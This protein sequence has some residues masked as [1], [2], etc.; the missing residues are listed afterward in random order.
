MSTAP[1]SPFQF[2]VGGALSPYAPSYISRA[3]DKELYEALLEGE[4][5]YILNARQIG[6]SSLR[7]QTMHRLRKAG[8]FCGAVDL[9][10]I[11][12]QQVTPDQWYASIVGSLVSSFQLQFDLRSWWRDRTHLS[13]INR[14]SEFIETVLLQA[15]DRNIVIFID[16][17]D[18]VLSLKFPA[19]DFFAFIRVCYNKRV[20]QPIFK[21]LSFALLGVATPSALIADKT[22]TPFNIGR[23]IELQGFR[24][25][26]VLRLVVGLDKVVSNSRAVL[27]QI[28]YWTGGQPFLTQKLCQIALTAHLKP[29][30][31][32]LSAGDE[33]RWVQDLVYTHIIDNWEAQDEPEHLRTI[34]DRLLKD[35]QQAG[36]VLGL[37]WKILS[38]SVE[39]EKQSIK[40]TYSNTAA[41]ASSPSSTKDLSAL[42]PPLNSQ[43]QN[44]EFNSASELQQ[45]NMKSQALQARSQALQAHSQFLVSESQH[46]KLKAQHLR[47]PRDLSALSGQVLIDNSL[48]QTE[49]LLS[50]LVEKR[51]NCLQVKN[52]IYQ[53]IFDLNWLQQQLK[54]IR[55]YSQALDAWIASAR[56]DTSRLLRGQALLDA[57]EWSHD[58]SL[59]DQDYQ[60]LTASQELDRREV[61]A[62][63]E[64]DRLQEVQQRLSNE[65]RNA[66]RQRFL[67]VL[68]SVALAIAISLGFTTY[69]QY[70]QTVLGEVRAIATSAEALL[71]S[72]QKLD[73]LLTSVK[74]KRLLHRLVRPSPLLQTQIERELQQSIY[75]AAEFNRLSGHQGAVLTVKTSSDGL[76]ATGSNDQSV[77]IWRQDGTLL[78]TLQHTATVHTLNFSPDGA[79]LVSSSLDG[80][81]YLWSREGK[82]I[83]RFQG[84]NVAIWNI[85]VSPDGEQIASAG[86]DRIICLWNK[87]G[88][89]QRILSGHTGAVWGLNFSPDGSLLVSSSQDRTIKLWTREG[90]LIDTF[91][92]HNAPVWDVKFALL[93]TVEGTKRPTI[94]SA[95]ADHTIKLWQLD[96]TLLKTLRGHTGEVLEVAIRDDGGAIASTGSDQT[97]NLWSS[98]GERLN[99]FK[100]HLSTI[101]GIAFIPNSSIMVSASDDNTARLWN[102]TNR[103]LQVLHGH[104]GTVW[105]VDFSPDSQMLAS[106]SADGSFKLWTSSGKLLRSFSSVG[107]QVNGVA[108][109]SG[110][111]FGITQEPILGS[112]HADGAVKVWQLDGTLL[113]TLRGHR[114]GVWDV[115]SNPDGQILASASDDKTIKL[116]KPD[117]TVLKALNGHQA[118]VYDVD[119]SRDGRSLVSASEDG[120]ARRWSLTNSSLQIFSRNHSGIWEVATSPNGQILATASMD[121]T[122]TLWRQNGTIFKSLQGHNQGITTV[123]LSTDNKL[124]V[125]GGIR[126]NLELWSMDGTRITTLSRHSGEVWDVAFSPNGKWIASAGRDQM[127]NLWDVEQILNLDELNYAC[128][129]MRD[130]LRTNAEIDPKDRHLCDRPQ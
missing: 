66:K 100:G 121:D 95:S 118:R 101:R 55:P 32:P 130:Y 105:D 97:I 6:K 50:G 109:I 29:G 106:A 48:E 70:Q 90:Q 92:G 62:K 34:R 83:K 127:I 79:Y 78:H 4:F 44:L 12:T 53:E 42:N 114:A 19:D 81:I 115:A 126:G 16:E 80:K 86:E 23:A 71:V 24:L 122:V 74:A 5:C 128:D 58:K 67:L 82:L 108:F 17:I 2:Q 11:G 60:F 73:A 65:K 119:F 20:E 87:A 75:A 33:A 22:R 18:S 56:Q 129:W 99:T 72:N 51:R 31:Y 84:H 38:A 1:H 117:G 116:W 61:E 15:I 113:K 28:L 47:G 59:S 49:L 27:K 77:K 7:V 54:S 88:V 45:L 125:A 3:A 37:Y 35:K 104:R 103:F 98:E 120:T 36:R 69:Y 21:R 124:L 52:R 26:E 96:G 57:L 107:D 112:A 8:V 102:P 89:L 64:A 85:A 63:L 10:V 30:N 25:R 43:L 91:R 39:Q 46:L 13:P 94:V 41:T 123:D 68:V 93:Q 110:D 14:L 40:T 111:G 76:I 9:T